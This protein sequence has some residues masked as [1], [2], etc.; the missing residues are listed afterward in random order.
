MTYGEIMEQFCKK[1]KRSSNITD[2]RPC[3]EMFGVPSIPGAIVVW[4]RDKSK[5]IYI[6]KD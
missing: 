5:M 4:F 2:W 6:P 1:V 3:E